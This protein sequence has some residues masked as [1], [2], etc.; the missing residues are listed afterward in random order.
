MNEAG[1]TICLCMIV[2][3]EVPVITRCLDSVRSLIDTW[4]IVDTGSTDG[5]QDLIREHMKDMP[6][7]LYERLWVDF[8]ANRSE[9]LVFARRRADFLLIIDADELLQFPADF[10]LPH[11]TADAYQF[12]MRTGTISYYKTQLVR[13][14][15]DWFFVGVV[16]EHIACNR[17]FTEARLEGLY[18]LRLT[19]GA[20][21]RDPLTFRK[22]ALLL[23]G[24]LLKEPTNARHMFYLAQS[25]ADAGEPLLA[26]DRYTKRAAMG[27]WVEEVWFSLFQIA[28]LK[29]FIGAPWP[30]VLTA[31]LEAFSC[32]PDRVEPLYQVGLH[33]QETKEFALAFLFFSRAI[34]MPFPEKDVLFVDRR[35]YEILLPLEYAVSCFY[36]GRHQEAIDTADRLL[37]SPELDTELREKVM[38][39]R[40][41][42]LDV[43][44]SEA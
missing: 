20:R 2:K 18:T 25:Y 21:A 6:G 15:L 7:Q 23:E 14:S 11:L 41:F 29:Q 17:P 39:N 5:T 4:V 28:K 27:G 24:A 42:S 22:D 12:K 36:V 3:N 8:A 19:D 40:T 10:R 34:Q 30:P 33:Y 32:R 44:A 38:K 31:Y 1:Q 43:L 26:I 9:S 35:V 16:H 37:G 13:D